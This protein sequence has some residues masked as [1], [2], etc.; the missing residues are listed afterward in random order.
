MA[1]KPAQ[2]TARTS[3]SDVSE[4]RYT[5]RKTHKSR[6]GLSMLLCMSRAFSKKAGI[7]P[8]DGVRL[9][10]DPKEKQGRILPIVQ[11][12]RCFRARS[13]GTSLMAQWPH[14]DEI[15]KHFPAGQG[16]RALK[17]VAVSA[18]E[19]IIFELP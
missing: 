5:V 15:E 10:L 7:K 12:G 2:F 11:G 3:P 16:P 14:N 4:L 6:G 13:K 18:Q 8:N 1:F 19:G 17:I 9:D